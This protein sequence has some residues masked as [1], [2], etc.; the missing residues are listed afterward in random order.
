MTD[1]ESNGRRARDAAG[2]LPFVGIVLLFPPFV[3]IF[4]APVLVAGVPLIV[5]YVFGVWAALI[6]V[7]FLVS[8]MLAPGPAETEH[9]PNGVEK[10]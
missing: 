3:Y 9:G 1:P 10:H 6:L 5:V 4:A 8:R 7:A 2:I